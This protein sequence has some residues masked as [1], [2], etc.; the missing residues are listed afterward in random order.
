MHLISQVFAI[1]NGVV[2]LQTQPLTLAAVA[3]QPDLATYTVSLSDGQTVIYRPLLPSDVDLLTEFLE[4]LSPRT[5]FF[6]KMDSY[7]RHKAQ[8]LCDAINRYDKFRMAALSE[9]VP[10][11]SMLASFE[12]AF[13]VGSELE[14]F[15]KYGITLSEAYTCR[16]GPCVRDSYQN[17]G[18]GSVLMPPTLEIAHRFGMHHVVLW[19][20]VV[21]E[22]VLAI[23]FYRKHGFR[24]VGSFRESDGTD[25][26]DMLLDL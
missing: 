21:Q 1:R 18:L 24:I 11:H 14:R 22:N 26:Y 16:F 23:H 12:F 3:E 19:G 17:R 4:S 2:I 6:W 20:G 7:D 9:G 13:W 15:H 8:E 5:R 25:C 10:A